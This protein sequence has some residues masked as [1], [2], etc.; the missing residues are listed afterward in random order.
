[1]YRQIF[2]PDENQHT[3]HLPREFYGKKIE[4]LAFELPEKAVDEHITLASNS[5]RNYLDDID[6]IADFPSIE[7]IRKEGWPEK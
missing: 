6:T 5:N 3:I 7:A 1:M 2:I 4:V